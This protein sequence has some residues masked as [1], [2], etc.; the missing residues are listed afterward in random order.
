MFQSEKFLS[1]K[2]INSHNENKSEIKETQKQKKAQ[3]Q[4][5]KMEKVVKLRP[6]LYE[7]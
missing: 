6:D 3:N 7:K 5:A 1:E 2:L 4:S